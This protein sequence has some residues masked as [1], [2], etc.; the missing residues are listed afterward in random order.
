MDVFQ[1]N[2]QSVLY[3]IFQ[4]IGRRRVEAKLAHEGHSWSPTVAQ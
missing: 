2:A 3:E 1:C 4:D